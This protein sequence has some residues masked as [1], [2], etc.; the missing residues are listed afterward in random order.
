MASFVLWYTGGG[1]PQGEAEQAAVM[2]A[3]TAWFERLGAA[4]VDPGNPFTPAARSIASNGA[5][6]DVPAAAMAGGYSIIRAE[7]L[8]AAVALAQSCPQ[9]QAGGQVTVY[10]TFPVM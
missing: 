5:V 9:L 10:E 1:T 6:A 4:V 3:W 2:Q 7:S 8:A